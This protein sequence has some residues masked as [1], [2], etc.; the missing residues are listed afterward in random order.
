[1]QQSW[2]EASAEWRQISTS[3]QRNAVRV[4][5]SRGSRSLS[6]NDLHNIRDILLAVRPPYSPFPHALALEDVVEMLNEIW[7][8]EDD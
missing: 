1:M 7:E 3:P 4:N 8:E 5:P 2:Q 6:S